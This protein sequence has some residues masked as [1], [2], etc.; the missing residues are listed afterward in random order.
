[1]VF[2][3]TSS[4]TESDLEILLVRNF[5]SKNPV[6]RFSGSTLYKTVQVV[7]KSKMV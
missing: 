6:A 5:E 7:G 3:V 2:T 1:M 4:A